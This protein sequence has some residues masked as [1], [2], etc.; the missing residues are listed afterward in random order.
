[1][2]RLIFWIRWWIGAGFVAFG[3]SGCAMSNLNYANDVKMQASEELRIYQERYGDRRCLFPISVRYTDGPPYITR[4]WPSGQGLGFQAGDRIAQVDGLEVHS[5]DDLIKGITTQQPGD[6]VS[7]LVQ[8]GQNSITVVAE[9]KERAEFNAAVHEV[10]KA[11]QAG[12]WKGCIR[13]AR[14]I[15]EFT[16]PDVTSAMWALN[17]SE[18]ERLSRGRYQV[19]WQDASLGYDYRRKLIDEMKYVPGGLN[20]IRAD[21]LGAISWLREQNQGSYARDLEDYFEAAIAENEVQSSSSRPTEHEASPPKARRVAASG[22]CFFVSP[23][24]I[25]V[26]NAHVIDGSARI[27]VIYEGQAYEASLDSI[28]RSND[29]AVLRASVNPRDYLR[30]S[31]EDRA[32]IGDAVFTMGFPATSILGEEAKYTD[33]T[34]SSLSGL[35]G[36]SSW[37]QITVPL[38]PGNS[39][40]PLVNE[41]GEVVGV[42]VA[43]AKASAF[44][45]ATGSLPQ[46]VNWAIKADYLRPMLSGYGISAAGPSVTTHREAIARAQ[47]ALCRIA[48]Y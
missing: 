15:T 14:R 17:C 30:L 44:M 21:V 48:A 9:C 11:I 38:Q 39:G 1:M 33:G 2:A 13:N 7:F 29:L 20:A 35:G 23:E 36:D 16:G 37:M 26:T 25:V 46:N 8:R 40:G 41:R 19:H 43:S 28:N 3:A 12:D 31:R 47:S 6:E 4:V 27:E 34:I 42:V 22:T 45:G 5:I 32:S 10:Y 24:G 18:A